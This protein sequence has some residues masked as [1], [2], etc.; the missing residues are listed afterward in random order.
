M[1]TGGIIEASFDNKTVFD[2]VSA[3]GY[4]DI[5]IIY[6]VIA[7]IFIQSGWLTITFNYMHALRYKC[8]HYE[9]F[10]CIPAI[11]NGMHT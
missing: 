2:E 9:Q 10:L 4:I 1:E 6:T 3:S 8:G 5:I 11:Q 7:H